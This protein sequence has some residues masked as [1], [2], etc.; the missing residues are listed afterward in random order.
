MSR[1]ESDST[2]LQSC[3]LTDN[4]ARWAAPEILQ[5]EYQCLASD[6]WSFGVVL[7]ELTT[8]G[9]IPY[10]EICD[11]SVLPGLLNEG[12]RLKKSRYCHEKT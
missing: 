12:E 9:G 4:R 6:V 3:I 5:R 11:S 2:K 1:K 7:Y 8:L 10:H